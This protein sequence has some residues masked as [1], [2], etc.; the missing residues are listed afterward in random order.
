MAFFNNLNVWLLVGQNVSFVDVK[1]IIK[2]EKK[3]NRLGR[4]EYTSLYIW[5]FSMYILLHPETLKDNV[6][7]WNQPGNNGR[8]RL[9]TFLTVESVCH[10]QER[11]W[12][13][14]ITGT[15]SQIHNACSPSLQYA[16]LNKC[17]LGNSTLRRRIETKH[18][19]GWFRVKQLMTLPLHP[20]KDISLKWPH[21]ISREWDI[22]NEG[23]LVKCPLS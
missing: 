18:S 14:L 3:K 20:F 19:R 12:A 22:C 8:E 23:F 13:V 10:P 2:H 1:Y 9:E 17:T 5:E 7:Y 15:A 16:E 21:Y 6:Y 4:R 11:L